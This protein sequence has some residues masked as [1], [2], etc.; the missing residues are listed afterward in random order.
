MAL[1]K[2][3]FEQLKRELA[4]RK[5]ISTE[6]PGYLERVGSS[7]KQTATGLGQD[8]QTQAETIASEDL[9]EDPSRTKQA[10]ALGR[11]GL[12]TAG[13]AVR[14]AF[15]PIMEAPGIKQATEFVGEKLSGTGPMQKFQEW[16]Q[17]HPEAAKDIM[18]IAD[19]ASLFGGKAATAPV[20]KGVSAVTRGAKQVTEGAI[21]KAP[22][23]SKETLGKALGRAESG[24]VEDALKVV[25]PTLSKKQKISAFERAGKPGGVQEV[26]ASKKFEYKPSQYDIEIAETSKPFVSSSKNALENSVSIQK[27]IAR[28]SEQ[29]VLPYLKAN[30]RAINQKTVN[31]TLKKVETPAIFKTEASLEKSYNLVREMMMKRV[32]E[33]PGT[34]E[35]LWEARK[36]FDEDV[37]K[38]FG[39]IAFTDPKASPIRHGIKDMRKTMNDLIADEIGDA[40]F[41]K[42]MR[43]LSN[44]YEAN[45]RIAEANYKLF[46]SGAVKRWAL[47]HPKL[48]SAI[49]WGGAGYIGLNLFD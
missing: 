4:A 26:G 21:E 31:S 41:K 20:Q 44:L 18:D 42:Q 3:Q 22:T 28:M 11:G 37:I 25:Q 8:L 5:G 19:V 17:K 2:K 9:Q 49:K 34:M 23:I 13:A 43:K 16:S 47:K 32:S 30:P 38:A 10:V 15:T 45:H 35:G 12:R 33:S 48:Y 27:E 36:L 14:S 29:E 46:G 24:T 1:D 6:E 39:E 7:L 40:T